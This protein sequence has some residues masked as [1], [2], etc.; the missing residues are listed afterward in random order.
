MGGAVY[1]G[2]TVDGIGGGYDRAVFVASL[3]DEDPAVWVGI[4]RAD[5]YVGV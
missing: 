4:R 2:G 3:V 1:G 5:K